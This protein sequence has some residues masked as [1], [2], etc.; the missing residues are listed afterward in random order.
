MASYCC[1]NT[2]G[3]VSIYKDINDYIVFVFGMKHLETTLTCP[4][5]KGS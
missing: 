5:R 2:L 4:S 1:Q 3:N